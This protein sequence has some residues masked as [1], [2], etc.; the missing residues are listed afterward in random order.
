METVKDSLECAKDEAEIGDARGTPSPAGT[1][2][3]NLPVKTPSRDGSTV[4]FHV[5]G[6]GHSNKGVIERSR[7]F[8]NQKWSE[9]ISAASHFKQEVDSPCHVRSQRL[10][11]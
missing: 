4:E 2:S 6:K 10:C 5:T 3:A 7:W 1:S 11:R 9:K 8:W